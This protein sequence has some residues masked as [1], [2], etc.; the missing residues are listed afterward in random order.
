MNNFIRLFSRLTGPIAV[1]AGFA[2]AA[3]ITFLITAITIVALAI[4]TP[5][6][7]AT[8]DPM[9]DGIVVDA[10]NPTQSSKEVLDHC[11]RDAQLVIA[12]FNA[13]HE[14]LS[15]WA[16]RDRLTT[17]NRDIPVSRIE[18]MMGFALSVYDD[19]RPHDGTMLLATNIAGTRAG[20][21]CLTDN[22]RRWT[23]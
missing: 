3:L 8:G 19:L 4:F 23:P 16:I 9:A 15:P 5:A 12:A 11:L 20:D 17:D 21:R 10:P 13:I 22:Y 1:V 2:L 6:S 18:F 14:G 7:A